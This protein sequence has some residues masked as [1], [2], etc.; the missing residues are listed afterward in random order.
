MQQPNFEM[1]ERVIWVVIT[2]NRKLSIRECEYAGKP[3]F[4]IRNWQRFTGQED[5][6]P[7]KRGVL[8]DKRL[9]IDN[10]LPKLIEWSKD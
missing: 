2:D 6:L 5:H 3:H 1:S 7:T 9:F 8:I 4:D 10:I